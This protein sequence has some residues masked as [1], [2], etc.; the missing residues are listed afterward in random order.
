MFHSLLNG[1]N[2]AVTILDNVLTL[3]GNVEIC[4]PSNI[5][6]WF[7]DVYLQKYLR[8]AKLA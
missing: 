2:I 8:L 1:E 5:I 4:V 6:I 3:S 7:L